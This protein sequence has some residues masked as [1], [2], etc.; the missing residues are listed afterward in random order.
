M[1]GSMEGEGP[2]G[3]AKGG[4]AADTTDMTKAAVSGFFSSRFL[5]PAAANIFCQSGGMFCTWKPFSLSQPMCDSCLKPLGA[6]TVNV[7]A[8][9]EAEALRFFPERENRLEN[10]FMSVARL[11]S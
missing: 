7:L 9:E 4:A 8:V 1:L 6:E 2:D 5:I 3:Q 10:E 11:P